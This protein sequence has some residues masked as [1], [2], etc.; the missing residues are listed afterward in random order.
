MEL[1]SKLGSIAKTGEAM[2]KAASAVVYALDSL[3]EKS[4]V[5]LFDRSGYRTLLLPAGER[6]LEA[7]QKVLHASDEMDLLCHEL[8]NGWE[9]DLKIIVEGVV[10]IQPI[11]KAL[12]TIE[13]KTHAT[14]IHVY[15]EYLSMVENAFF[16]QKA[17]FMISVIPPK[18]ASLE[19]IPLFEVPAR[20]VAHHSHRL[21]LS[22][23]AQTA[24]SLSQYP[25]LTVR[26]SDPRLNTSTVSLESQATIR[27]NDFYS[28]KLAVL[29]GLGLGWLPEYMIKDELKSGELKVINWA[30]S[31]RH[32]FHPH[33]YHR[34]ERHLGRA[35][36]E[37][38]KELIRE[39]K[40]KL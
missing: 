1:F 14:R 15:G 5:A 25:I 12:K 33:L 16:E 11:F 32:I 3:E 26:G 4:G 39:E 19:A 27:L 13:K 34:G 10:P 2:R 36:K 8:A 24:T 29:N 17:N 23:K 22:K 6:L 35:A 28:K 20:L 18:D 30:K 37:F 38:M 21:F 31:N 9:P 7:S 40:L